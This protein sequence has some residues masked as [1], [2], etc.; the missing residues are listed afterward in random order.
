MHIEFN[1]LFKYISCSYLSHYL[2]RKW[3][4]L[5]IQ[6]HLM[7]LFIVC[8]LIINLRDMD[9]NTS[10]VLIYQEKEKEDL[11]KPKHSN[12]SH[13]LIYRQAIF[14]AVNV[15]N[16]FK[17]ISCSYLSRQNYLHNKCTFH[18]QIH[19]MFLFIAEAAYSGAG[20]TDSNT[21]HVL[22]YLKEKRNSSK[23]ETIQIHLMFLF[24]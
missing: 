7:F 19:L 4:L 16:G 17:Y 10:H 13:V 11:H 18:I 21:S 20:E 9:S 15:A 6:I 12:T 24:I 3:H 14:K 2:W 22:I 5:I 23:F 8:L 1:S